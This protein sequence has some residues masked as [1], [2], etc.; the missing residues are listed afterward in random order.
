MKI[1]V[2]TPS[3]RPELIEI[4]GKCLKRQTFQDFEWLVGGPYNLMTPFD[5]VLGHDYDY[6]FIPEPPK[7]EGDYY[8]LNK[9]WNELFRNVKGELIIDYMDGIWI[10]PDCLEKFW[11][12][13]QNNNKSCVT[14]I[15]HQY[16]QVIN[17]KP[18]NRMWSDPRARIDQGTFYEV[19]YI[20][21]EFCLVS[22]P[23]QAVF[24]VGGID[25]EFDKYAALAEKEMMFRMQK[26][27]YKM[28]IDQTNEYRAIHHPRLTEEWDKRYWSGEPYFRECCAKVAAGN[29][30]K[31]NY[32]D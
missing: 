16:D 10:P 12:H 3:V 14:A 27:G 22:F 26:A 20:E 17:G 29:R 2:I 30:L 11:F 6:R 13:Y 1:S 5:R 7:K 18:E 31:L 8:G 19:E 25:E 23:K 4:V 15:G 24:D 21:M 9:A 32:L 28:Y